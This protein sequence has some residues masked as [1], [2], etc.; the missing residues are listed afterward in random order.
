VNDRTLSS[1]QATAVVYLFGVTMLLVVAA[2][3]VLFHYVHEVARAERTAEHAQMVA[4]RAASAA[5]ASRCADLDRLAAIPAPPA[6]AGSPLRRF[7]GAEETIWRQ[8]A[9]QL[10]CEVR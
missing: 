2:L 6:A 7:A 10:G 3:F 4:A 9:H 1:K 8:R 5:G